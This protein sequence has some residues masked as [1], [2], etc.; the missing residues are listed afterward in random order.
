M[1]KIKGNT[2]DEKELLY[3]ARAARGAQD[4]YI[5]EHE[6]K[7]AEIKQRWFYAPAYRYTPAEVG[8]IKHG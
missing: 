2:S 6:K 3:L 5:K 7:Q 8:G 4:K 1:K